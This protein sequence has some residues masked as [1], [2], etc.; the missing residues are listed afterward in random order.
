MCENYHPDKNKKT[1]IIFSKVKSKV[2]K[3]GPIELGAEN[4]IQMV[5]KNNAIRSKHVL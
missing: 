5:E 1:N 4:D 3:L 2:N